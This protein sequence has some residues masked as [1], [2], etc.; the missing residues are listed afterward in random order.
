MTGVGSRSVRSALFAVA[1]ATVYALAVLTPVGQGLDQMSLGLHE[2]MGAWA[3]P[4][5]AARTPVLLLSLL[6]AG[7]AILRALVA[8]RVAPALT[9]AAAILVIALLNPLLRDVVL[10]RPRYF[11]DAGFASN[12]FPS[13]HVALTVAACVAIVALAARP[14]PGDVVGL[15]GLVPLVVAVGSVA[16]FAHR[17]GDVVGGALLAGCLT[18]WIAGTG[19][20]APARRRAA[21]VAAVATAVIVSLAG[22]ALLLARWGASHAGAALYGVA[23]VAVSAAAIA[24]V[25]AAAPRPPAAAPGTAGAPT[26]SGASPEPAAA[27][28]AT[29][30]DRTDREPGRS[31]GS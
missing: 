18:Q 24:A 31:D 7:I 9:A 6:G 2:W 21:V 17:V 23:I 10:V 15:L 1:L 27:G 30:A 3:V 26:R 16:G 14:L 8:R 20:P 29:Q 28:E 25:M 12:T 11:D 22:L 13:G 19:I 5:G 4:L